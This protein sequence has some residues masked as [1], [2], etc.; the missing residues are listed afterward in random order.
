VPAS[1]GVW[2][3]TIRGDA[4]PGGERAVPLYQPV[5]LRLSADQVAAPVVG[6]A[7]SAEA[8]SDPPASRVGLRVE[9]GN[10]RGTNPNWVN[11]RAKVTD[12]TTGQGV[13]EGYEVHVVAANAEGERTEAFDLG[14]QGEEGLFAGFVVVPRGGRWT[15]TASVNQRRPEGSR[16]PPVIYARTA[17]DVDVA[18]GTLE[19]AR[20]GSALAAALDRDRPRGNA[21]EAGVLWIHTVVAIGWVLVIALLALIGHPS[22]RRLLSERAAGLIDARLDFTARAA[23]W[24]TALVVFTGVYNIV[25]STPYAPPLTPARVREVFALP[26]GR[27]YYLT[28]GV[29]LA[30]YTLMIAAA[31]PLVVRARRMSRTWLAESS[32]QEAPTSAARRSP[33]EVRQTASV[34][35]AAA[36][37]RRGTAA[38]P[39]P[40]PEPEPPVVTD[41][42]RH[43][44][45][46][47]ADARA[48][49]LPLL[50]LTG[51]GLVITLAVTLLKYFH[52]LSEAARG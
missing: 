39:F 32:G 11:V 15:L 40:L 1:A 51:G 37:D 36:S 14:V 42:P 43:D 44:A 49:S 31:V 13:S 48:R 3:V 21:V 18:G 20:Q 25:Q 46:P 41:G 6:G 12:L 10:D 16:E 5:T 26:Y 52:L 4:L 22:G 19:S 24:L 34:G 50:V 33:W 27:A 2:T 30:A 9:R 35:A 29:K 47:P 8:P 38:A 7:G 45:A 28:L 17:L 23:A